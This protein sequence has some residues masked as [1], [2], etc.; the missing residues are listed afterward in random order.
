MSGEH[1]LRRR[2]A[3][4][5][6][7]PKSISQGAQRSLSEGVA[8][9]AAA[10]DDP[11]TPKDAAGWKVAVA[12]T[13]KTFEPM[14]EEVFR[15]AG[16]ATVERKVIGGVEVGVA[17]PRTLRH[18]DRAHLRIHGGGFIFLG[19]RYVEADAARA[20]SDGGCMAYSVDYRMPPDHP[21]PTPLDDCVAV[22]RALLE[23]YEPGKI[24][25]SG[26]SAGGNLSAALALKVRD[27]GLPLP[28]AVGMLTPATDLTRAGDTWETNYGFDYVLAGYGADNIGLYANG[29]D[30]K[31]P[32]L[33]PLF[34]DFSKGFPPTFLQAG[35]R[36]R[37]LSDTVRMH[38]ALLA[39]GV[40]ADLHVWEAMPHG[41]FGANAPEDAEVRRAL[42]GFIDRMLG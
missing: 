19:G 14:I 11:P 20:A 28:G 5:V 35:T 29:Y 10:G 26:A 22:Y 30:L 12:A 31:H 39:A 1:L 18:K 41:G 3:V 13:D 7:A 15:S 8:R 37:L 17:T 38:R 36:D 32:Y 24:A 4:R 23:T 9:L 40:A 33:S 21:F 34:G 27:L 25:V 2:E 16:D 6:P 42:Q